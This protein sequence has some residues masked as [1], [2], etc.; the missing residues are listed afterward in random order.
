[1]ALDRFLVAQLSRFKAHHLLAK[2]VFEDLRG[3][4]DFD[5]ND[6]VVR[7]NLSLA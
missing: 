4:G 7:I 3:G 5:F 1:V 6:R 2:L